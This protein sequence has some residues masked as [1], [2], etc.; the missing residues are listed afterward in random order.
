MVAQAVPE[1]T[2]ARG[3]VR[4]VLIGAVLSVDA[5][6]HCIALATLCF[7]GGLVG[8]LGLATAL[9]LISTAVMAV[10]L[11]FRS[12]LP[13]TIG[14]A[15][16]TSIAI[17]APAVAVAALAA[18]G[19]EGARI[20]TAFAVIGS[21]AVLSGLT[22]IVVGYLG[23]GNLVRLMPYPV[24]A[25][26]L[27]SSGWLLVLAAIL[28]LTG[29]G[30]ISE[31]PARLKT[32]DA[33]AMLLPALVLGA[34]LML[35]IRQRQGVFLFVGIVLAAI[36][37]F[38]AAIGLSGFGVDAARAKGFLPLESAGL[39]P[40]G[41]TALGLY[42]QINWVAVAQAAPVLAVVVL[43]NLMGVLLNISGV[44]LVARKDVDVNCELRMTGWTN[45][46]IGA[47]GGLTSFLTSGSTAVANKAA[48]VGR[49]VGLSFTAVIMVGLAFAG[50]MVASVPVFVAAGLLL[51]IGLSMLE[52]WLVRSRQR[53]VETDWLIILGIVVV[54]IFFGIVEAI[55]VGL[56]L[57]V[58]AFAIGYARLPVIRKK[59]DARTRRSTLQRP[60]EEDALL[61]QNGAHIRILQ[62]QGY[63]FFGSLNRMI[64]GLRAEV[65][66]ARAGKDA[67]G[68]VILD[69]A[70]VTGLDSA[71]CA[72][73]AKLGD[74]ARAQGVSV[75]LAAMPDDMHH[76]MERWG[77]D[78]SGRSGLFCWPSVDAA[79]EDCETA[80]IAAAP[81][82]VPPV[83]VSGRLKLMGHAHPRISELMGLM[84]RI[85]LAQGDRLIESGTRSRDVYFLDS[86][87]LAVMISSKTGAAKR[88]SSLAP[89]AVVGEVAR[90]RDSLRTADVTAETASVVYCLSEDV[91]ARLEAEDRD[92]A[93]LAHAIMATALA[94]KVTR[95][96][97]LFSN[98]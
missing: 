72:A 29:V 16:D 48:P 13:N 63:L 86:G 41:Q 66:A 27:A 18:G 35:A 33:W 93:A 61:D 30:T 88:V 80:L 19:D 81:R 94:E 7:A 8:G 96:S 3:G 79:L 6:G 11:L 87:R 45:L 75:H 28:I 84:D 59:S 15:Q 26:F 23:L 47:I 5:M 85:A 69:L 82:P 55:L 97:T 1:P 64:L 90:Y 44:E 25:G 43:I 51:F 91:L 32:A 2:Q 38:Y 76:T 39:L 46:A 74:Q 10:A 67:P 20:A 77:L 92:L 52:D 78:L 49:A 98:Q 17:L 53:L 36:I 50:P 54:T 12:A 22:F 65:D 34:L 9:F 56:G 95:T 24:A 68:C 31:I 58:L 14:I 62:L 71:G 40:E 89:G 37:V 83:S 42:H 60:P 57:A 70:A 73:L 4:G 21:A